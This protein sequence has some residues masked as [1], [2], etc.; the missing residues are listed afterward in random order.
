MEGNK[1]YYD[2]ADKLPENEPPKGEKGS[3]KGLFFAGL[4]T[5]LTSTLLIMAIC[6]VAFGLQ[7]TAEQWN[8]GILSKVEESLKGDSKNDSLKLTEGSAIDRDTIFKLQ[9]LESIIDKRFYLWD[10]SDEE[11]QDGI[12]RGMMEAVGDP[13]TEYYT[14]EELDELL[15]QSEGYFYGIGA[16]VKIDTATGIPMIS[17]VLRNSPAEDAQLRANDLIYEVDGA[18]V[19]GL[20]LNEAVALI[21][22]PEGTQ[23]TLTISRQGESDYLKVTVTRRRVESPTVEY[24]LL[25]DDMALIQVTEF[26]DVTVAQFKE[27]LSMV[28]QDHARGIILDLRGNPGGSLGA[29]VEMCE[30]ILPKGLIVYTVDKNGKRVEYSCD[31]KQELQ[32][33]LVVLID[34]NSASASE[35]MT[36]AIKD[37]GIGTLVGTRTYGKGI[38]Q[39]IIPFQDGSAVKVTISAYY[40]P[41]GTNIHGIGIEPDVVCEFDSDYYYSSEDHPDNQLE[42]AKEVL[43]EKM[44][45]H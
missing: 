3:G 22:G 20:T 44:N 12:F 9:L 27:A 38:V 4:V 17:G 7:N 26:D 40:S 16:T 35:V 36:G 2:E 19:S 6:F 15:K 28:D 41:N 43:R 30:M 32:K 29:V 11:L 18:S 13:Y 8:G 1:N 24:S 39:Q 10:V 42:K 14:A 33:P 25:E 45:G 23:V 31:G 5:G 34:M 37:H 21:R